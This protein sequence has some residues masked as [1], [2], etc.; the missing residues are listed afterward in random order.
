[1]VVAT[2]VRFS[3][4]SPERTASLDWDDAVA[5]VVVQNT[6]PLGA[7]LRSYSCAV[8]SAPVVVATVV[9]FSSSIPEKTESLDWNDAV[10]VVVFQDIPRFVA[11]LH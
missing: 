4:S 10:V 7:P 3:S 9:H 11:P 6:P 5:V 2:V 8:N 1:V